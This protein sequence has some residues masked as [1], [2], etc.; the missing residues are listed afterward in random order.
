MAPNIAVKNIEFSERRVPF[1]HPFRFGAVTVNEASQLFVHVTVDVDGKSGSGVT[2]ELMV[3]KWFN[4]DPALSAD[5]TVDQLRRSAAIARDIYLKARPDTAFGL[6]AVCHGAQ[7]G[8]CGIAGIPPLAAAFGAAEI[9]KAVLDAL[10]RAAGTDFFSG[11]RGNIAGLDARLTPDLTGNAITG[12]LKHRVPS[13]RVAVRYTVGMLD[14][15]DSVREAAHGYRYFKLKLCGDPIK[16]RVRLAEIVDAL[17]ETD[18]RATADAN[19]QY[20]N[21][22]DL[23]ALVDA[24]RN[25]RALAPLA[26]RLLYIEQPFAREKTWGF[27]LAALAGDVAFIIDEADD[28]YD[29]FPRAKTL[30]YRGVSTKSCKGLYKSLLNGARAAQW[31][32]TA[33]DFFVSAEDLTCQPGLAVQQDT[34][35]VALHGLSHAERNGHHYVDGFATTPVQEAAAFLAAHPDLYERSSG[36]VRLSVRDGA[37]ATG[38]LAVPGFAC[39]VEPAQIAS[40]RDQKNDFKEFAS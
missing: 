3:P 36:A 37:L 25:D 8:E 16:D 32:K 26:G 4:K 33:G 7:V 18:Y 11:M 20:R 29:A 40:T 27:D 15:I 17:G 14:S 38:S 31:S 22:D 23:R 35:L 12:F 13:P 24:I 30:G 6:H 34:A 19:E 5:Q 21:P 2:A 39:A 9:D 10:L 28:S 1:R